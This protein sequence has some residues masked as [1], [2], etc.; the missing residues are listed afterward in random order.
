[1][2]ADP[3]RY[4]LPPALPRRAGS[5]LAAL[6]RAVAPA[7]VNHESA[8]VA[9]ADTDPWESLR[10][11]RAMREQTQQA[12]LACQAQLRLAQCELARVTRIA[13]LGAFAASI[14]HDVK[15]PLA[16]IV[17]NAEAGLNWLAQ[18]PPQ[19][20]QA[21]GALRLVLQAGAGATGVVRSL[22][23]MARK[24]S[25]E[26]RCFAVDAA[27]A[28]VL[29]LLHSE[30]RKHGVQL[31]VELAPDQYRLHADRIQFQQVIMNL[32]LNAV[33]SMSAVADRP[34][35]LHLRSA[36][37]DTSGTLRISVE[38]NGVGIDSKAA[39][40]L[41]EPWFSTKPH[42]MGMGLA[43]CRSIVEAHG[44]RIWSTSHQRHGAAFHVSLPA[45]GGAPCTCITGEH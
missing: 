43:I 44:G 13:T 17:L 28:E 42:G 36:L 4:R 31:C 30:L 24:S 37:A 5:G 6:R 2:S 21:R 27:I 3:S 1:M 7:A 39:G 33:E 34:R 20:D 14:A 45:R 10:L 15:Q 18:Q 35:M 22:R 23:D 32:L 25:P 11:E 41:Y 29:S 38:D 19:L 12:L 9:T 16:A 26:L 8:P 40:H